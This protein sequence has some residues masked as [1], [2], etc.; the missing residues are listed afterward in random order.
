MQMSWLSSGKPAGNVSMRTERGS[1]SMRTEL[2]GNQTP[3]AEG[4]KG[5]KRNED[6]KEWKASPTRL[7][8]S[9]RSPGLPLE[10]EEPVWG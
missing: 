9:S 4:Q 1:V 10:P 3:E 5:S 7:P 8:G 2:R 6:C